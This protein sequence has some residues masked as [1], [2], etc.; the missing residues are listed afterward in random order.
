MK[1]C[2]AYCL[3]LLS[4]LLGSCTETVGLDKEELLVVSSDS[5]VMGS[6]RSSFLIEVTSW[7]DWDVSSTEKWDWITPSTKKGERGQ[8]T[9]TLSFSKNEY[10]AQ[11]SATIIFYNNKYGVTRKINVLQKGRGN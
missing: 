4:M 5:I 1:K 10:T 3:V 6:S 8:S 11:R 2:I 9:V 7:C